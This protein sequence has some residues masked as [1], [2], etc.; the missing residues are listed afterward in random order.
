MKKEEQFGAKDSPNVQFI[1]K[2]RTLVEKCP[3]VH[4][5]I[6]LVDT[7]T[8]LSEHISKYVHL[9]SLKRLEINPC[10]VR[11]VYTSFILRVFGFSDRNSLQP[12]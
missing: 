9:I 5:L 1:G 10:V 2:E 7:S 12:T 4:F 3:G 6:H 8:I 11:I